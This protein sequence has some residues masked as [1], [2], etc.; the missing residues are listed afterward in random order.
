VFVPSAAAQTPAP[1]P[2]R[3]TLEQAQQIALKSHPRVGSANLSAKAE[4][5]Q[6]SE[7]RSAYYPTA[8]VNVTSTAANDETVIASGAL[9]TSS[10][11]TRFATGVNLVQLVSDFGRTASL[12]RAAK[13][14]YQAANDSVINTRAQILLQVR[15]AYFDVLGSE[16]VL[17]AAQA[18]LQSRQLTLR[19]VT[20]ME[21]S[22]LRSSLDVTF[23][24][25]L[26]SEAQ[27]AVDQ[28]DN[29]R[30]AS[31]AALAAALGL[32]T[33]QQFAL[34]DEPVPGALNDEIPA[35]VSEALNDRPDLEVLKHNRDAAYQFAKA[36]KKLSDPTITLLG[37][38]GAIP[39]HDHT[40]A[41][42]NYEAAGVNINIPVFNGG[43]F[44]AR[45]SEALLRAQAAEKDVQTLSV[46]IARDV[47]T[48]WFNANNAFRRLA[49][50]S[51][52][53]DQSRKAVHLAQARYDA[54]LSSIVELNQAQTSEISA[55]IDAAGAK[56]DYLSR[57][58]ELDFAVGALR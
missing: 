35:L 52:L 43:L 56:Y 13:F 19:Q 4:G 33:T 5:R 8:A 54:G 12:V 34:D 45:H 30:Q 6:V 31:G 51:Q 11:N 21:Q 2:T 28:A 42:D 49:V 14:R 23:A 36:E 9:A 27:L 53:V 16:A 1:L 44:A 40:I 7:A 10:L 17:K 47:R 39:E 22:S 55:E 37:T 15:R 18:T 32:E 29:D 41:K 20:V 26:V 25:V 58:T 46:Q 50:T 3:L 24:Q 57:R 48:S 38:A